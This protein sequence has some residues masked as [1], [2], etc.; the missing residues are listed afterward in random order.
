VTNGV[1]TKLLTPNN[2]TIIDSGATGVID[3]K[4]GG[5]LNV[6]VPLTTS[7]SYIVDLEVDIVV[8]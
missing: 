7:N 8:P 6:T 4:I 5:I 1:V 3:M 2:A